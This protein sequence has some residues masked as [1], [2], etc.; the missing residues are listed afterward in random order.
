[1]G[2]T[3]LAT[4][5]ELLLPLTS[6][7]RFARMGV[8]AFTDHGTVDSLPWRR[9]Y[10]GSVWFTAAM[11]HLSIAVAHGVGASTHIHVDGNVSF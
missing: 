5:A 7:L 1:V 11:F 6:P 10:G 3:L 9:G 4:S 2:N 8:S